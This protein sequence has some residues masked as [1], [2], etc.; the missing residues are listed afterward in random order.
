M[1]RAYAASLILFAIL[2]CGPALSQTPSPEKPQR[3][4][5]DSGVV[6]TRQTITPA[7]VLSSFRGRVYGAAFSWQADH[8]WVLLGRIPNKRNTGKLLRLDWARNRVVSEHELKGAP[9][10]QGILADPVT[11]RAIASAMDLTEPAIAASE[12]TDLAVALLSASRDEVQVL[13][14][15]LGSS[16]AGAPALALRKNAHGIRPLIVPLTTDNRLAVVDSE[17]GR[18][19]TKVPTG[20]APFGAVINQAGTI[21]VS[22]TWADGYL[23]LGRPP[24]N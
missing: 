15:G 21:A 17:T 18:L 22:A 14:R 16:L 8:L 24:E 23:P 10:M 20:I 6:P 5:S 4:S 2:L 13:T 9:G 3:S 12:K 1:T 19:I 11:D 7:G